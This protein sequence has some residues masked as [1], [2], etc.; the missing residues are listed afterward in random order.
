MIA[1]SVKTRVLDGFDDPSLGPERW[2]QLL[3]QGDTD[4]MYLTWPWQR[5]WWRTLGQGKLLLIAAERNGEVVAL[6][7]LFADSGMIFF[8]GAGEAD[9]LDFIGDLGDPE[10][11][12]AI[13]RTARECVTDF[14]GFRFYGVLDRSRTGTRLQESAARLGLE[15]CNQGNNWPAP[16]LDI[17]GRPDVA[18]MAVNKKG[19]RK[20][21]RYF[22]QQGSL[23]ARQ[24]RD[25]EE[26]LPQLPEFFA[27]HTSRWGWTSYPSPVK[28]TN[29][30][31]P[32]S[33]AFIERLTRTA[34]H[35]G[36][37]RFTRLDWEG[38][39]IAFEF[40]YCYRGTYFGGTSSFAIDLARR[41]PGQVLLRQLL[42][43]AIAEGVSTYDFGIGDQ[44]YKLR[45]ATQVNYM[46]SWAL[47]PTD[48]APSPSDL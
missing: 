35:T 37:L 41:S 29:F 14:E 32:A 28:G 19:L 16:V 10:V 34:A 15:C 25:G 39:P 8:V 44:P 22:R 20:L 18:R 2:E 12:D 26:I 4:I 33:R 30:L 6:A 46:R 9:Y 45:F 11:L 3:C 1:G 23:E 43:A 27:Q 7:P 40:G 13:L 48:A 38:R 42:L 31:N 5:S 47:Y 24:F 36:W 17:A 21:E